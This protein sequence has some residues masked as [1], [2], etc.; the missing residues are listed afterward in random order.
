M[1]SE[2]VFVFDFN[3]SNSN[4]SWK[5][6]LWMLRTRTV[7]GSPM[8][9]LY[10]SNISWKH[11]LWILRALSTVNAS[12]MVSLSNSN[13]SWKHLFWILRTRTVNGSP[14][15]SIF[16][17][18]SVSHQITGKLIERNN[19]LHRTRKGKQFNKVWHSV[20]AC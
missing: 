7:N 12:P 15:V 8:V 19:F 4:I 2:I 18:P 11:L 3:L 6:L 16:L 9:S 1:I 10:N 20:R 13:I 17:Y 5:H 14:M